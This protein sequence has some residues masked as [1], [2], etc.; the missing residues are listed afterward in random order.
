MAFDDTYRESIQ[1][2]HIANVGFTSTAKGV[3][4][5]SIQ[6]QNP[7][8]VIASQIPAVDVVGT[9]GTL[10]A[11]GI[12][13]GLVEKHVIKLTVDGSVNGNKAWY[14]TEDNC[15][16]AG[17][18]ARGTVRVKQWLR[19]ANTEYKLRLYEDNGSETGPGTEI[20]PS[21]TQFNWE[22]DPSAGI[23]YFD[24]DPST[25]GKT[26]PLWAE[27]YTYVGASV[28][29]GLGASSSGV[30]DLVELFDDTNE[31]SG[32][33][34]RT[35][36]SISFDDGSRNLTISGTSYSYYIEGEKYTKT[37]AETVQI[38]ATEGMH[39]VYY[40]DATLSHTA[41]F[42]YDLIFNKA[43]V[44]AIYW[45]AANATAIYV[46][47]ER[48]GI[49]M[50]GQTHAYLHS[51][52]GTQYID[53]LGVTDITSNGNGTSNTHATVGYTEGHI[54]DED[55]LHSIPAEVSPAT[56]P[57]FYKS[58]VSGE[59][60]MIAANNYPLIDNH[61][62]AT[63]PK[64]NQYT[65]GAWQ[66]T[67][68][69]NDN[70][71]L[72]H[73]FATNDITN[74]VIAIAGQAV[75][76][77]VASARDGANN[78]INDLILTGM[79]FVEFTP[80]GTLIYMVNSAYTNTPKARIIQDADGNDYVDWRFSGYSPNPQ[81]VADHANLT[82]REA[83]NSHP[84]AAISVDV[85]NFDGALGALDAQV[86]TA[87]ETLDDAVQANTDNLAT[88]SGVL[89]TQIDGNDTDITNLQSDLATTS[90]V[91]QTNIDNNYTT[92]DTKIDTVSGT[93]HDEI[94][95][96]GEAQNE[97][98]ELNDVEVES[99]TASNMLY[100]SSSG[101]RD[102]SYMTWDEE[103]G[104]V[105]ITSPTASGLAYLG[106]AEFNMENGDASSY[107][108]FA[109][110]DAFGVGFDGSEVFGITSDGIAL[111]TGGPVDTISTTVD[112]G[113][114]DTELPTAKAVWDYVE[115]KPTTFLD[116][117]DTFSTYLEGRIPFET[118]SGITH[119]G[120]FIYENSTKTLMMPNI[121]LTGNLDISGDFSF[122]RG[123]TVSHISTQLTDLSTDT[124]LATGAA[125]YTL[126]STASGILSTAI[127]N[128]Y[129]TLVNLVDTTSGT[130]QQAIDD[131][132]TSTIA[133]N[134]WEVVDTPFEQ[135]RPKV[136]H[137]G[138]AMYTAG[139]LTI[140]GDLTVSGTTTTVHS[141]E[142][143][144]ADKVITVNAGEAGAGIT[145]SQYAGIEV[146]RG[147]ETNYMF[148]FDEV[149]D[150]FRVGI[151]GSLQA[152]A[153]REDSPIDTRVAWWNDSEVRFDT[154]GDTYMTVD[155][156]GHQLDMVVNTANVFSS[157]AT[158][159]RLGATT[160][161]NLDLTATQAS[162]DIGG[163]GTFSTT[164]DSQVVGVSGD[165]T[166]SITQSTDTAAIAAAGT[167]EFTVTTA[168]VALKSGTSVNEIST[169]LSA[170]S[171]DDQLA[172]AKAI[173]DEII[174]ISGTVTALDHN[175]DLASLQGGTTDEYYHLTSNEY[176]AF[177]S[178]GSTFTFSQALGLAT[179]TTVNEIVTTAIT[180]ANTDDQLATAKAIYTTIS[181]MGIIDGTPDH[182]LYIDNGGNL[183]STA[184][185]TYDADGTVN[186][187]SLTDDVQRI[188]DADGS[189][190]AVSASGVEVGQNSV[191]V[192]YLSET[193]QIIGSSGDTSMS[194]DQD[195]DTITF[196][197]GGTNE[198]FIT[199][200]GLA[201]RLGTS[202]NEILTEADGLSDA[203]TDDQL[204]TAA[205]IW[206][207]M[208]TMSGVIQ[209]DI[210]NAID[211]LSN[212]YYNKTEIDG[213]NSDIYSTIDTT[214]GTLQSYID[215]IAEAQNEFLELEDVEVES[216]TAGNVLFTTASGVTDDDSFTYDSGSGLFS[217]TAITLGTG[218]SVN[219]IVTTVTSGTTDSQLPT[220]KAVWDLTEAAAAA[221]HIHYDVDAT[222][223]SDT[224]WTY[225]SGF[226]ET[227]DGLQIYVNGVK[228]RIGSDYDCTVD[229]PAGVLTITF[230]YSVRTSDWVN[231]NYYA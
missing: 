97:F 224:S 231:V 114:L 221:V 72:S 122:D 211:N 39:Y 111:E 36:S 223:V 165:T 95:A 59:W 212:N 38:T 189:Y 130:L 167:T 21:E 46:G 170:A 146:D 110:D 10:V 77:S 193:S 98:L 206:D 215:A 33:I 230:N 164:A 174:A 29:D 218:G 2:K 140:G 120:D 91:L 197:A 87:L 155:T 57:V 124:D 60:R 113:S 100:T 76:N 185:M 173:Y 9:Y 217:T 162:I 53:G 195:A 169:A 154:G 142:L 17:H 52:F 179:G 191:E 157:T 204:A 4:N 229:V 1:T 225:G 31:P 136:E 126:V 208:V 66:L 203:S 35:S 24:E 108:Y 71:V 68:T 82:G 145:G 131:L 63:L 78:E 44:A 37:G 42:T 5:E 116:L 102:T 127:T 143:T 6:T 96:L 156:S 163:T 178:D 175:D 181:G 79:P 32:F 7:H 210:D 89:Q 176:S 34:D 214:S 13:A 184:N 196:S 90:G 148:V 8:Q 61:S 65:G 209:T 30:A 50:D 192:I 137:Q 153:T 115:A 200:S 47:D 81:S 85:T 159:Q 207:E 119:S 133:A 220:A 105:S 80:I 26:T 88:A 49:T 161:A 74:P 43:Y 160:G 25:N 201:L 27:V 84:A 20:F 109:T 75:Y 99:Y 141:E 112:G 134:I 51:A 58:G 177:S 101:V 171:T 216:Y 125:I 147:S 92:L 73:L 67:E 182:M 190:V 106:P 22:Y 19:Y 213:F 219:E 135:I 151:S 56:I 64:W 180:S 40:D 228:Q 222:H 70:L 83:N 128:N 149:Q 48:H 62:G 183:A 23:V 11:D 117:T 12:G 187:L 199:T 138:K 45:D 123:Q 107:L 144:V 129:N 227:P 205:L 121:G 158:V 166:L 41:T 202:A 54:R 132:E 3:T 168:G 188:G 150:N 194:I 226:S 28:E 198:A 118:A 55:V 94:L 86:Q 16:E 186:V 139:N 93:L 172:T 103:N 14:A 18:A 15:T 69:V 152:V 104:E